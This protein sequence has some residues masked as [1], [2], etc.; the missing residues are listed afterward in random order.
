VLII[1]HEN[2]LG[3]YRGST[4]FEGALDC[5]MIAKREGLAVTLSCA[6]MKDDGEFAPMHLAARVMDL[7]FTDRHERPVTS[8]VLQPTDAAFVEQQRQAAGG[9][10]ALTERERTLLAIL[11]SAPGGQI[12]YSEWHHES[13]LAQS[14]FDR[15][16]GALL[17]RGL[18]RPLGNR[19]YAPTPVSPPNHPHEGVTPTPISLKEMGVGVTMGVAEEDDDED[20]DGLPF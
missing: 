2:K 15:V 7:G 18:V 5:L 8:V 6:K 9:D 1:H 4:A 17:T 16:R 11:T 3:G 12:T 10:R 14:T 13:G 20:H 19:G